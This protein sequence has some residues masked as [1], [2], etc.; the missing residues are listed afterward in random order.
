MKYFPKGKIDAPEDYTGGR[1]ASEIVSWINYKINTNRKVKMAPSSVTVLTTQN[2]QSLVVDGTGALVEFYA[3]WC[4]HCKQL[5]PTYEEVAKVYEGEHVLIGKVDGT[6]E[7]ELAESYK[8]EVCLIFYSVSYRLIL[9]AFAICLGI[10]DLKV[11]SWTWRC[12]TRL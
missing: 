12:T 9:F 5:A 10:S 4:G 8:I 6:E 3:P 11:V 1:T 2:F 7:R